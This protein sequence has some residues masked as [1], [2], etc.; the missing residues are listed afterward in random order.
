MWD[1]EVEYYISKSTT[2]TKGIFTIEIDNFNDNNLIEELLLEKIIE[3]EG[4]GNYYII[5]NYKCLEN[6]KV[7]IDNLG[8]IMV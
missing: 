1:Y 4:E 6:K 3:W 5:G 7:D 8:D 2:P